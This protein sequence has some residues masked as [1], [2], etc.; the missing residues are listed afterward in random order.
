MFEI[1]P[2]AAQAALHWYIKDLA[3]VRMELAALQT[4]EEDA[5]VKKLEM[6][7]GKEQE[8]TTSC[9]KRYVRWRVRW[10]LR[11]RRL[12]RGSERSNEMSCLARYTLS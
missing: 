5:V 11:I 12:V 8:T 6:R 10:E 9:M 1:V 3:Q 2:A 4:A 7:V